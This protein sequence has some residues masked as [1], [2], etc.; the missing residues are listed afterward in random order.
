MICFLYSLGWGASAGEEKNLKQLCEEDARD[1]YQKETG[2]MKLEKLDLSYTKHYS[3]SLKN[4]FMIIKISTDLNLAEPPSVEI[5]SYDFYDVNVNS[6]IGSFLIQLDRKSGVE[7]LSY[8]HVS[9]VE[10]HSLVE[11]KNLVKPFMEE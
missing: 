5:L 6:K 3:Q 11:W 7:K 1:L 2:K 9:K 4:C 10:C 8:C